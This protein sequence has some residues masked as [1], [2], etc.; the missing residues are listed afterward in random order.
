MIDV[1]LVNSAKLPDDFSQVSPE[2]ASPVE[3]TGAEPTTAV[4]ELVTADLAD[5]L[6]D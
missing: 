3:Y 2:G 1:V 5:F 4:T 6:W